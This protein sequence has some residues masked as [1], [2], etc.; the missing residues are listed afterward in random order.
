MLPKPEKRSRR[1]I[2]SEQLELDNVSSEKGDLRHKRHLIG[3]LLLVTIGSSF[4][5][6]TYKLFSQPFVLPH[7][8][9]TLPQFNFQFTSPG[10]QLEPTLSSLAKDGKL[11]YLIT[12]SG[13]TS[14][15]QSSDITK[16]SVIYQN[17][18]KLNNAQFTT[19]FVSALPIGVTVREILSPEGHYLQISNPL[20]TINLYLHYPRDFSPEQ[21]SQVVKDVYWSFNR[22]N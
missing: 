3:I 15:V 9:I 13:S 22:A 1:E 7:F 4:V 8:N 5:L 21:L 18:D 14:P 20:R 17:F 11:S 16:T 6:W 19:S 10:R 2:A 12:V